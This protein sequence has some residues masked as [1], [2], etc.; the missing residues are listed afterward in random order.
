MHHEPR[1]TSSAISSVLFPRGEDGH[2]VTRTG[3]LWQDGGKAEQSKNE[4]IDYVENK[5][6][7]V[8]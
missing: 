1:G 8:P 3:N 6:T 7:I 5:A 2:Q 4:E